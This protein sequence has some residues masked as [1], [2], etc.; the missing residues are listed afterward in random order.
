MTTENAHKCKILVLGGGTGGCTIASKFI[1]KLGKNQVA[2]IEPADLH[3]YQPMLTMIG[4]GMKE[5]KEA[6]RPMSEVLPKDAIWIKEN[7]SKI[8]AKNNA[9]TTTGGKRIEYEFLVVSL[10]LELRYDKIPGVL[11]ALETP[12]SGV[13]S[14]YSPKYV[15]QTYKYLQDTNSG[16]A[17]F[18]FPQGPVKCAGAP[19]KAC[20]ISEDFL[21]RNGKRKNVDVIYRTSL[22]V[23]FSVKHYADKL[24]Q[25][26][27]VRGIDVGFQQELISVDS[28][29]KTA[30]FKNLANPQETE[31]FE[32]SFLHVTPPMSPPE[33]LKTTPELVD[34]AG[35]VNVNKETL[36]SQSFSNVYG[37]GDCTN[38]PTS[39]TAAAIAAQSGVLYQN[40][41]KDI[42]G[43]SSEEK[44]KYDGYTSCPLVTG[45]SSVILAEFDYSL[46]PLETFPVDQSKEHRAMFFM[47][48]DAMPF[49]Y[50]NGMLKGYWN[51]PQ[52]LRKILH[53]GV[54]R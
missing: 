5:L 33:V 37:I 16:K 1:S 13:A 47:K 21:R 48:K 10:G 24:N 2:I 54:G 52:F 39:K 36:Q 15:E 11:E 14:N 12:R 42:E 23:I 49:L 35:F 31:K 17:I 41:L 26:C 51:G 25:L 44:V 45:Y 6:S 28:A 19:L 20:L 40:L 3:Y 34:G 9:V 4:G 22:P 38:L 18:T 50:W 43:R 32:F 46:T 8:D 53:F 27:A 29:E 7:V 30:T